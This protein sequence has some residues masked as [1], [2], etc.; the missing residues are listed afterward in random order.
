MLHSYRVSFLIIPPQNRG[1]QADAEQTL[2]VDLFSATRDI[3]GLGNGWWVYW[4]Q[5]PCVGAGGYETIWLDKEE[6]VGI[7]WYVYVYEYVYEYEL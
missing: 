6:K 7:F 2:K 3:M 4:R 1:F 5:F